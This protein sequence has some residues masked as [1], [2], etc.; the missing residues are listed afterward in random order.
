MTF[1]EHEMRPA[2]KELGRYLLDTGVMPADWLES[3]QSVDRAAFL[4]RL[5]WPYDMDSRSSTVCD[6]DADP[7]NWYEYADS[8]VPITTQWDDGQHIG[9]APGK[10][11]TSSA[12]MPSVVLSMLRD[13]DVRDG[14]RA[15]EIGTGT[16]WNAG[17]LSHRLGAG[18]VV[19]VEVDETVSA[20]ALAALSNVGLRPT[21]VVGDGLEGFAA[22]APYDRL[23]ATVGVRHIP[24]A[25]VE[26]TSPGG[27]I[28]APWGTHFTH[29]DHVV[30]L[31]VSADGASA[32]GRFTTPVEFM[33]ARSQRPSRPPHNAYLPEGFPGDATTSTT[34]LT[35]RTTGFGD[36]LQHPFPLVAGL[37]LPHCAHAS[38]RRGPSLSVWLYGL[39]DRSW[40]AAVLHDDRPSDTVYQVGERR[41][42][43]E[44]EF[45]YE[46]WTGAGGPLLG[47][48]GMTVDAKG[49][50]VWIDS[51]E[52]IVGV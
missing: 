37:L 47:R 43:D 52:R 35:A 10:V 9:P 39:S 33:K 4:P 30:R 15:L 25:W 48:F 26:Q 8:D 13:L 45:A 36:L 40:A 11:P 23:I 5:M 17:L 16:G 27:V 49:E 22:L 24:Y 50:R 32:S 19:S 7:V 20:K 51:P 21:S 3:F 31:V 14:M 44:L 1:T 46:W 28:V 6:R 29:T 41:L 34:C 2:R 38:D 12:S 18:S 42:W